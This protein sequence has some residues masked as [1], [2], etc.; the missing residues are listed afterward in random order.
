MPNPTSNSDTI[1]E[2]HASRFRSAIERGR[3]AGAQSL[4]AFREAGHELRETKKICAQGTFG[5]VIARFGC[6][7][8]WAARLMKLDNLWD[9]IPAAR[10]W[11]M[12]AGRTLGSKEFSV[13]GAIQLVREYHSG[14]NGKPANHRPSQN[15][16]ARL[17]EVLA[18]LVTVKRKLDAAKARIEYLQAELSKF[19]TASKT[20]RQPLDA[21]TKE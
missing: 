11:A 13:D 10:A 5:R 21:E 15:K 20:E 19:S 16:P 8:A 17:K 4:E 3:V 12:A 14:K 2:G 18:E 6:T 1:I 9:E 7:R